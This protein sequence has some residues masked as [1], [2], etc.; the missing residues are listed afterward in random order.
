M[1]KHLSQNLSSLRP[2]N[3]VNH[4]VANFKPPIS[5][6]LIAVMALSLSLPVAVNAQRTSSNRSDSQTKAVVNLPIDKAREILS[7]HSFNAT[8]YED[9]V[10]IDW[11]S[12]YEINTL[13]FNVYREA[14]GERTRINP[15][16]ILGSALSTGNAVAQVTDFR[17]AWSDSPRSAKGISV[18]SYWLEA[19]NLQGLS[20]W[21]GPF[22]VIN[23][24]SKSP[25]TLRSPSVENLMQVEA[26]G[27]SF[28]QRQAS[29]LSLNK[30]VPS[31]ENAAPE[32]GK[33]SAIPSLKIMIKEEGWY[34]LTQAE[35]SNAGWAIPT[36]LQN[37]QLWVDGQEQ[38]IKVSKNQDGVVVEFYA[39]GMDSPYSTTR[40][41][42]LVAGLTAGQ[43]MAQATVMGTPGQS[44]NYRATVQRK[45][46]FIYFQSL[47]NGDQENFFGSLIGGAPVAQTLNVKN[48][49]TDAASGYSELTIK[50]QGVTQTQH[51]INVSFNGTALGVISLISTGQGQATFAI[52][53]ALLLEGQNTVTLISQG[54]WSDLNLVDSIELTYPHRFFADNDAI[55][56]S[57]KGGEALLIDGFT[58]PAVCVVDITNPQTPVEVATN[59]VATADG[60]FCTNVNV[61]GSGEHT[62]MA[63]TVDRFKQ[64]DSLYIDHPSSLRQRTNSA[65]F[66]IITTS[67]LAPTLEPLKT[68]RQKQ[69]FTT[70][71]IDIED[72]YD[73]FS[74]GQKTPYAIKSFLTYAQSWKHQP[75]YV[76]LVGDASYDPKDYLGW[77][78]T[79]VVPTKLI[80][81]FFAEAASDDWLAD[82]DG[83]EYADLAIGRLPARNVEEATILVGKILAYEQQTPLNEVVL[84]SDANDVYDFEGESDRLK[85]IVGTSATVTQ[86][87]KGQIGATA[88]RAQILDKLNQGPKLALYTGHGYV[89]SW[90]DNLITSD[91]PP[92][93]TNRDSYTVYITLD[94]LNGFFQHPQLDGLAES[95]VKS[96]G[97]GVAAWCSS[98]LT[99]ADQQD[100]MATSFFQQMFARNRHQSLMLGDAVKQ[101]KSNITDRDVRLSWILFG[102]P[103]MALK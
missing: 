70:Q 59:V 60:N 18:D 16:L 77:G 48:L 30:T 68:L 69:R 32:T 85:A 52:P 54:G 67:S 57:G 58:N 97:G 36:N 65:D 46:R 5:L 53:N 3:S 87:K 37:L 9:Q 92:L 25:L 88:A 1:L 90:R 45:D 74:Y 89:W 102:D 91:D 62:L 15:S 40:A 71:I 50:L 75:G 83:D 43:R 28:R 61:P 19:I 99:F 31:L 29:L 17:Y 103:T 34:R 7:L 86:I 66:V 2:L 55:K 13:G 42:Y 78:N 12:Q 33:D 23:V 82:T 21:F 64:A 63:L 20:Q 73:E 76:L 81:S 51:N 6:T 44:S 8:Q 4:F 98:T 41:Y 26:G 80:D 22:P 38:A 10:L 79:D 95:F 84:I 56:F 24:S 49:C 100:W 72:I 14:N 94:C 93:F 39:M 27:S 96:E 47:P 35:M 11:R 101:A